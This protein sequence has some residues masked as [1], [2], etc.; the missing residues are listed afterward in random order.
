MPFLFMSLFSFVFPSV[1]GATQNP[2]LLA[3]LVILNSFLATDFVLLIYFRTRWRISLKGITNGGQSI[4]SVIHL[5][6]RWPR[7]VMTGE[8]C[9]RRQLRAST[10]DAVTASPPV[11]RKAR[12]WCFKEAILYHR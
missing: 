12:P 11:I 2:V 8:V 7:G 10:S 6:T 9:H 1:R 3:P 5:V 4:S